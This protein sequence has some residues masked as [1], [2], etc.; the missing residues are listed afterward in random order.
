MHKRLPLVALALLC[1]VPTALAQDWFDIDRS[2]VEARMRPAI[3]A[4]FPGVEFK[5]AACSKPGGL[6]SCRYDLAKP[7]T[8][9]IDET[10][11]GKTSLGAFMG[12]VPGPV[13]EV[14]VELGTAN[15]TQAD[16]DRFTDL[17]SAGVS[18]IRGSP[19]PKAKT[20]VATLITKAI[21]RHVDPAQARQA[22]RVSNV[23]IDY[24]HVSDSRCRVTAEDD[25]L[26]ASGI[27]KA[28]EDVP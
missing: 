3:A 20:L 15:A 27:Y 25:Y 7:F 4:A 10:H 19:E 1:S 16:W 12:G 21:K 8:V 2:T 6:K 26:P 23:I 9:R 17:C 14:S 13:Y 24:S 18:A 22:D 11:G 5:A 28:S